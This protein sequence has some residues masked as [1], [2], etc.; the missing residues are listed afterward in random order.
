[1]KKLLR[2]IDFT[3]KIKGFQSHTTRDLKQN[4]LPKRQNKG[5]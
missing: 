1:M 5:V 3:L 4:L 2:V